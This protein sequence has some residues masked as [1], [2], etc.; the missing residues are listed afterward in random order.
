MGFAYRFD[1]VKLLKILMNG[2][3]VDEETLKAVVL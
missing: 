2:V 1:F 3:G